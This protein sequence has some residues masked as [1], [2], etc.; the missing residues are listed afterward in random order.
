MEN[1]TR[2]RTLHVLRQRGFLIL[3]CIEAF[4]VIMCIAG[5]FGKNAVY[6]YGLEEMTVIFG[7]YSEADGGVRVDSG[8][9]IQGNMVEFDH[10]SL[11]AGVY[12]VELYYST[13]VDSRQSCEVTDSALGSKRIRTN[14]ALL[15]SGLNH[16]DFEMWLL[17]KSSQVTVHAY[18]SGEGSMVVSGLIVRQTNA[19]SRIILF[20]VLCLCTT[21][22]AVYLYIQ[23]DK[24]YQIPVKNKTITFLLVLIIVLASIPV[25]ADYMLGGADLIYHLMR[26]EGI[27]DGIRAGQFPIRISPE[28]QQ[29]YG[30]ASPIFYG[31]TVLYLAALF[32]LIGF[33]VTTSYRLFHLIMVIVTVLVSYH[34]FK[35]IFHEP[36]IGVFCSMLYTL[37]I[38]RIYK[39]WLCGAWGETLGI[40]FL[41]VIVYG[42]YRVFT[43][44]IFEESYRWSWLPL[45]I[46]FSM[47]VQSHLLTCEMTGLFTIFLC[48]LLWRRVFR[49][50]TF[51]VLAKA[52]IY[53]ILLSAWFLI[54]FFDYM[55]TGNFVIQNVSGRTI[56]FRGLYPAHMLFT[57]F[58]NGGTVFWDEMGMYDTAPMGVGIAPVMALLIFA[59]L[60]LTGKL[61]KMKREYLVSGIIMGSFG[62][63]AMVM[64]LNVFPWDRIQTLNN[65]TATLV[66]SIQFPNR[67]LSIANICLTGVGGLVGKYVLEYGNKRAITIYFTGAAILVA[68]SSIYLT[69]RL[70]DTTGPLRVY[71]HEGMGTGY[72]SGAEYLPYGADASKFVWHDPVC[73]GELRVEGYEK[74]S[75]GAESNMINS[76]SHTEH[77]AFSL[78]YYKGYHAYAPDSGEEL[79]CYAGDN[80]EVTVDIPAGFDGAVRV[81]FESPWYWRAGETV[82]LATLII[83][84]V[85]LV[86]RQKGVKEIRISEK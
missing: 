21:M 78:L 74:K 71:N 62:V 84:A 20:L 77:A 19:L 63:L 80:F 70:M 23:Y 64:S 10:L 57:Y 30:Y 28:W 18:Y 37:S 59:G 14:G 29:G 36:Y 79:N 69:D 61:Q 9:G 4:L 73:S 12:Q 35:K 47:L 44:D 83:L 39:T 11:P 76:G 67:F 25:S 56:Q 8:A 68:V 58:E 82:T 40:M 42:F 52:V 34:C 7:A 13:D 81:Q 22:N 51:V 48:M 5:L 55:L 17:R 54:P 33:T 43:Q 16:T 27:V 24:R 46:G 85:F 15:F 31:E 32:R 86:R 60:L 38:Y 50:K 41:P 49:R 2:I 45:T 66:S 65:V 75:L 1:W 6:E 26:V 72:I 3:L 53:S